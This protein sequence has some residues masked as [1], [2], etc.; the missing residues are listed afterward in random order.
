M[1]CSLYLPSKKMREGSYHRGFHV[2]AGQDAPDRRLA[3]LTPKRLLLD[4]HRSHDI[5]ERAEALD[6][7]HV[8][9][10]CPAHCKVRAQVVVHGVS[11]LLHF[12]IEDARNLTRQESGIQ[13][14][15]EGASLAL[16][17]A[18]NWIIRQTNGMQPPHPDPTLVLVLR[19]GMVR[20]SPLLTHCKIRPLDTF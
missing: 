16:D 14:R 12:R 19:S 3:Y 17:L 18:G 4:A 1:I 10:I 2:Q 7:D 20:Q 11:G 13:A 8:K 6:F 9:E 5:W 15:W